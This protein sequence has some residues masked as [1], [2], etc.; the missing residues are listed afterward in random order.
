MVAAVLEQKLFLGVVEVGFEVGWL[1][2][3]FD[4]GEAG[5]AEVDAV[6]FGAGLEEEACGLGVVSLG[7]RWGRK[8]GGGKCELWSRGTTY[9]DIAKG[10]STEEVSKEGFVDFH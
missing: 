6:V 9:L 3:G 8:E 2:V 1:R 5:A 10:E 4:A 7:D